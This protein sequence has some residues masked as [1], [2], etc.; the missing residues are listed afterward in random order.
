M[1]VSSVSYS[2]LNGTCVYVCAMGCGSW[3]DEFL[4]TV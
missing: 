2:V 3:V 4:Y 1:C